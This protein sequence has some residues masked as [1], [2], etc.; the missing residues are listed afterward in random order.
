MPENYGLMACKA[1][2][3]GWVSVTTTSS[4]SSIKDE[5]PIERIKG[6]EGAVLVVVFFVST[7]K[8]KM[9]AKEKKEKRRQ[10]SFYSQLTR[11]CFMTHVS[12]LLLHPLARVLKAMMAMLLMELVV[13]V[14]TC[15]VHSCWVREYEGFCLERNALEK[16]RSMK[17][18]KVREESMAN[19]AKMAEVKSKDLD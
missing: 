11:F 12:I 3:H 2:S 8:M 17:I 10:I 7:K 6:S 14:Q 5:G 18:A 15:T 9:K 4:R 13:L 1:S 19:T 16:K